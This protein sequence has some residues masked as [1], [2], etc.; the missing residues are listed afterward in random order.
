MDKTKYDSLQ[1]E[2]RKRLSMGLQFGASYVFG[3]GYNSTFLSFRRA[4]PMRRNA[5]DPGDITHAFKSNVVYD[6]PFGSG[7]HWG[8]NVNGRSIASS[9][10][11]S[12]ASRRSSRAAASS[13]SATS[14]SWG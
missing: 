12:S 7:R 9:A 14:A 1:M 11:G 13:T 3:H 6:L 10:A 5:G 2:L 4:Q 8:A